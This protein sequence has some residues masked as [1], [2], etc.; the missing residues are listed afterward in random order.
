MYVEDSV[1]KSAL[2]SRRSVGDFIKQVLLFRVS[3]L[4]CCGKAR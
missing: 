1:T 2:N 3:E 4:M